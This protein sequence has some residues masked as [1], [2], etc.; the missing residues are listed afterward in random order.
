MDVF[1]KRVF[2]ATLK[3]VRI[4]SRVGAVRTT[5]DAP[6]ALH[7]AAEVEEN[8]AVLFRNCRGRFTL[9]NFR[10][11]QRTWQ[12]TRCG[13]QKCQDIPHPT[14]PDQVFGRLSRWELRAAVS[15]LDSFLTRV[16]R[17]RIRELV[18]TLL[19]SKIQRSSYTQRKNCV[20]FYN[21]W[22]SIHFSPQPTSPTK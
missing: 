15:W 16:M 9:G 4:S 8:W 2:V 20:Y 11:K 14:K 12:G 18:V 5:D 21:C 19:P 7:S 17:E 10:C 1:L 3:S 22:C 6:E 13:S